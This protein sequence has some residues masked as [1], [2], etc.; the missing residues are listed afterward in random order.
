MLT[1][2]SE[3]RLVLRADNADARLTPLGREVG[4]VDDERWA[5]FVSKRDAMAEER[6]RLRATRVKS[7]EAIVK[8]VIAASGGGKKPSRQS[9]TLEELIYRPQVSYGFLREWGFGGGLGRWAA[10]AVETEV[11]YEGFI[12]RQ[13]GQVAK[14]AGKMNKKIP[15]GIDYAAITTL[16]MEAREKLAKMQ[17]ST[18]GQASRIGGVTPADVSSLSRAPRGGRAEGERGE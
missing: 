16:R 18:V 14:V 11:K 13:E 3:Y 8:D 12:K 4:L 10:E 9:F 7:D 1:S 15:A 5:A 2:R 17:P 6:E